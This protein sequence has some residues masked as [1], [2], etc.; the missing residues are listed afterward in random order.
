M[1]RLKE[2]GIKAE[3]IIEL[4]LF[5]SSL[6]HSGENISKYELFEMILCIINDGN[7]D[8]EYESDK[9]SIILQDYNNMMSEKGFYVTI[10]PYK[11]LIRCYKKKVLDDDLDVEIN[12][13]QNI[14]ELIRLLYNQYRDIRK[15]N[16]WVDLLEQIF[17]DLKSIIF[18]SII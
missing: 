15:T 14:N 18:K 5:L 7:T 11:K 16:K 13:I 4:L 10:T 9:V 8:F 17:E 3:Y 1:Y 2:Y 6:M 12:N